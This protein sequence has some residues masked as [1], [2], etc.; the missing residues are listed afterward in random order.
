MWFEIKN[1]Y[2]GEGQQQFTRPTD[3]VPTG[4][5]TDGWGGGNG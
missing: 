4:R 2:A 5:Q 1:Y 3:L